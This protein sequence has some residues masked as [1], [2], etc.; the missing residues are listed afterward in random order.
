MIPIPPAVLFIMKIFGRV[1]G[2]RKTDGTE[3]IHII[4]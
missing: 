3:K 4:F 1:C 2:S